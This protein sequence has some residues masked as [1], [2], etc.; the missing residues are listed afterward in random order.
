MADQP[1]RFGVVGV[2]ALAL[3]GILPHL[4]Q[5]DVQERL[6]VRAVCDPVVERAGRLVVRGRLVDRP[7]H[8]PRGRLPGRRRG[9]GRGR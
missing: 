3:R 4:T 5:G 8:D 1:V 7:V 2:G 9:D 6:R